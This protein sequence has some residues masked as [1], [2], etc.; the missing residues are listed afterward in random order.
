[1][2]KP[3]QILDPNRGDSGY[4]KLALIGLFIALLTAAVAKQLPAH[5]VLRGT[6]VMNG[7]PGRYADTGRWGERDE[8]G[9]YEISP[10]GV[11][12]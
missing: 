12:R 5:P 2:N 6:P 9:D 4:G 1:M 11:T 10:T 3:K 8:R 7:I